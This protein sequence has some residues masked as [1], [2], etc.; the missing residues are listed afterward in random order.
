MSSITLTISSSGESFYGNEVSGV[1]KTG[2]SPTQVEKGCPLLVDL[3]TTFKNKYRDPGAYLGVVKGFCEDLTERLWIDLVRLDWDDKH[4]DPQRDEVVN[5]HARTNLLFMWGHSQEPNY[6]RKKGTVYDIETIPSLMKLCELVEKQFENCGYDFH[7]EEF[8]IEGNWYPEDDGYISFHGDSE[9]KLVAGVRLGAS[10]PIYFGWW[11]YDIQTKLIKH[12]LG[13]MS[14]VILDSGDLYMMTEKTVGTDWN[15]GRN[16]LPHLRHAAGKLESLL[17]NNAWKPYKDNETALQ[18][19]VYPS[20]ENTGF[21]SEI[22]FPLGRRNEVLGYLDRL[23]TM[24]KLAGLTILEKNWWKRYYGMY[25]KKTKTE[26]MV[27]LS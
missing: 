22:H 8:V 27:R 5:K 14:C 19:L 11:Q 18:R 23:F 4:W 17:Y 26:V 9:R 1:M 7:K 13:S 2:L 20:D 12:V 15:K 3:N 10:N 25:E 16:K 21:D 24:N 6:K